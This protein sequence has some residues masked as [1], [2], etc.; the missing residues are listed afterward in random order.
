MRMGPEW[1]NHTVIDDEGF[2]VINYNGDPVFNVD[3]TSDGTSS[4]TVGEADKKHMVLDAD[5]LSAYD[6][7]GDYAEINGIVD[8]KNIKPNSVTANSI[9]TENL[10]V[11]INQ[12]ENLS[13]SM[14]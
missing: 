9:N 8:G 11:G 5:G 3:M 2:R 14:A 12:V 4:V 6:E 7:N 10:V 1:Y 13:S